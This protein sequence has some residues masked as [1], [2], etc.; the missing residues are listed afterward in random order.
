MIRIFI[1]DDHLLMRDGVKLIINGCG[2]M[3]ICGEAG[4]GLD[5]LKGIGEIEC[6]LLMMDLSMPGMGGIELIRRVR[7]IR[8]SLPILV[9]SMHD[10]SDVV[11]AAMRAGAKGFMTKNADASRLLSIIRMI[12]RGGSYID[13]AIAHSTVFDYARGGMPHELL[14]ARERQIL[15]LIASGHSTSRIA[16]DLALSPKTV[17]THKKNIMEKLGVDSTAGMVRYAISH[18]LIDVMPPAVIA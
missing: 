9:M 14:S 6:D 10:S 17:S 2:E 5:V 11:T 7:Q 3:Q 15:M 1:A 4:C 13:P 16:T 18:H 8:P 12:A